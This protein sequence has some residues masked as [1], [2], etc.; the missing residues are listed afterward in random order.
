MNVVP[1]FNEFEKLFNLLG[2][3]IPE[4]EYEVEGKKLCITKD[5]NNLKITVEDVEDYDDSEIL[6]FVKEFKENIKELDDQVF[7]ESV[8]ETD[9]DLHEFNRLLNLEHFSEEE[10]ESVLWRRLCAWAR[11]GGTAGF[12]QTGFERETRG[13][14]AHDI[15]FRAGDL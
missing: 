7:V 2:Q 1:K 10:T 14:A 13:S 8:E 15:L 4:G 9:L 5:D 11:S 12:R 3:L 6:E